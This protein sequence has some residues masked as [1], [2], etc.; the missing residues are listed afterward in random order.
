MAAMSQDRAQEAID[1][2]EKAAGLEPANLVFNQA[3]GICLFRTAQYPKALGFFRDILAGRPQDI[4]SLAYCCE[5][6]I[7]LNQPEHAL[8][9]LDRILMNNPHDIYALKRKSKLAGLK[10]TLQREEARRLQRLS[11]RH[12]EFSRIMK[13]RENNKFTDDGLQTSLFRK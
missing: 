12:E 7:I 5:S 10:S 11:V 2:F 8:E 9:Y 4:V 6:S 1:C 13:E 3:K